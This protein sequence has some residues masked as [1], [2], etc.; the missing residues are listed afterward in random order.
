MKM[1]R[2]N[3]CRLVLFVLLLIFAHLLLPVPVC[4]QSG[5]LD[6]GYTMDWWTV[7]GGGAV[8]SSNTGYSLGGSIGQP[9]AATWSKGHYSLFGGFWYDAQ[10]GCKIYLPLI[11]RGG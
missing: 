11:L 4:A 6:T 5:S 9:D 1:S 2:H 8:P 3:T 10:E 7:D